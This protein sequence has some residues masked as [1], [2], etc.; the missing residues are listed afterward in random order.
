MFVGNL[1][2]KTTKDDLIEVLAPVG[3]PLDVFLPLDRAT[4]KPRGFAFVEFAEEDELERAIALLNG[5][6]V[7]GR[8]LRANRAEDRPRRNGVPAGSRAGG[9]RSNGNSRA[10]RLGPRGDNGWPPDRPDASAIFFDPDDG[11]ISRPK[12]S[13]RNLRARKRSL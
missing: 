7:G 10:P 9:P 6:E 12:G 8:V 3:Q 13:R 1:S 11:R 2:F 4:N 5:R